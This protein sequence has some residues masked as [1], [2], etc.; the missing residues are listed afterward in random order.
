MARQVLDYPSAAV[1]LMVPT[2]VSPSD[3]Y[4]K[5]LAKRAKPKVA[6][7]PLMGALCKYF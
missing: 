4:I 2:V 7:F 5:A 6:E 1:L 3:L